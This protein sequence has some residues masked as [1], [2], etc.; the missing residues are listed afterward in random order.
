MAACLLARAIKFVIQIGDVSVLERLQ[1]NAET[2]LVIMS[3]DLC[4]TMGNDPV[5]AVEQMT[6]QYPILESFGDNIEK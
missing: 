1:A 5:Q 2:E 3:T 4:R 6:L